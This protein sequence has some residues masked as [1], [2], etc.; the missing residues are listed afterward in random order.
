MAR[1]YVDIDDTLAET[2]P[3]FLS[4][5]KE[6]HNIILPEESMKDYPFVLTTLH[7]TFKKIDYIR[8]FEK[9]LFFKNLTPKRNSQNAIRSLSGIHELI[10]IT[11]RHHK[12]KEE[13]ENWLAKF[14]PNNFSQVHLVNN[15]P[16]P[17][18]VK[19]P[20]KHELCVNLKCQIAIE[21]DPTPALKI[22]ENNIK[23]LLFDQLWNKNINHENI[24]RVKNWEEISNLLQKWNF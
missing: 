24:T 11:G 16:R 2:T 17:N 3:S 13:T 14:F 5:L 15:H 22:A 1:I 23:V 21:D 9:S 20:D 4:Y 10:I 8:D 19:G 18:E 6:E 7:K 12:L